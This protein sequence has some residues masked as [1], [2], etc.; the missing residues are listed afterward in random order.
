MQ[1]KFYVE[2]DTRF[3]S[4]LFSENNETQEQA[5]NNSSFTSLAFPSIDNRSSLNISSNNRIFFYVFTKAA[6][7]TQTVKGHAA[8]LVHS[9]GLVRE[10]DVHDN[11]LNCLLQDSAGRGGCHGATNPIDE[12]GVLGR[13]AQKKATARPVCFS[14]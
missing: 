12:V 13:Q 4:L 8:V 2:I 14:A 7:T 5:L 9:A 11:L 6:Q 1:L 3:L 10:G